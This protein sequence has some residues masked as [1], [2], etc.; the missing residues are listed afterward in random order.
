MYDHAIVLVAI[1]VLSATVLGQSCNPGYVGTSCQYNNCAGVGVQS[2][3]NNKFG[4]I[5]NGA[6]NWLSKPAGPIN[7]LVLNNV[8]N[9]CVGSSF[10]LALD[11]WGRLFT[12]GSN[13]NGLLGIGKRL[14]VDY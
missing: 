2:A 8:T 12:M 3:G 11:Y 13:Q 4:G 10:A 14:F 1:C 5:G 6:G 9:V 7:K